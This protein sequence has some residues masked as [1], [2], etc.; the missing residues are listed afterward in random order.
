[1]PTLRISNSLLFVVLSGVG[2]Y[3]PT[4]ATAHALTDTTHTAVS[5]S[6][7]IEVQPDSGGASGE[8]ESTQITYI[9]RSTNASKTVPGGT[10]N[11]LGQGAKVKID[12]VPNTT[13][14][15]TNTSENLS[16]SFTAAIF[17]PPLNRVV[18]KYTILSGSTVQFGAQSFTVSGTYTLVDTTIDYTVGSPTFGEESGFL[19]AVNVVATGSSGAITFS[20]AGAPSYTANLAPIWATPDLPATLPIPVDVAFSGFLS[21]DGSTTPFSG[22][23]SDTT[24]FNPDGSV[25]DL[26]VLDIMTDV[27]PIT[28]SISA[29]ATP[30]VVVPEP[31]ALTLLALGCGAIFGLRSSRRLTTRWPNA[32]TAA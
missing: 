6:T 5:N 7:E 27:G 14:T 10:L 25:S 15:V 30:T 8:G 29:F 9:D 31:S 11:G 2:F 17:N 20:L 28:G 4:V 12:P 22:T 19:S 18:S 32:A 13:V 16:T 3:D 1:M 23:L 24:T 26:D 21:L